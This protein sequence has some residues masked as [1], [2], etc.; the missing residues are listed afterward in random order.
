[1]KTQFNYDLINQDKFPFPG[2]N[3]IMSHL[4]KPKNSLKLIGSS[5][6]EKYFS[7][8]S[9]ENE[10]DNLL[11]SHNDFSDA[12]NKRLD[13]YSDDD[14]SYLKKEIDSFIKSNDED[15]ADD[16]LLSKNKSDEIKLS[17]K[18]GNNA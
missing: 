2:Q 17:A 7:D 18:K 13:E 5:N 9:S 8:Y 4:R 12:I 14:Y 3:Q 15:S 1:M 11:F 16:N 10:E 6:E